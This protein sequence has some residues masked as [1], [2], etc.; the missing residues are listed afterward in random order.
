MRSSSF[1]RAR[2][3]D[4]RGNSFSVG[5]DDDL[6]SGEVADQH[7]AGDLRSDLLLK[8]ASQETGAVALVVAERG[9]VGPY[10]LQ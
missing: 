4:G 2:P 3:E 10:L 6:T 9:R 8:D 5:I 1:S 7:T